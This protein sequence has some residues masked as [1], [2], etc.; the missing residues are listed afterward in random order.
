MGDTW[1]SSLSSVPSVLSYRRS[2][3][4]H[5]RLVAFL[6]RFAGGE[7]AVAEGGV[8]TTEDGATGD[9]APLE[10]GGWSD[11]RS[12]RGAFVANVAPVW[13]RLLRRRRRR[14]TAG[15]MAS[16]GEEMIRQEMVM[17]WLPA[18]CRIEIRA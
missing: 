15:A 2:S 5:R 1:R 13:A 6:V 3:T 7:A 14:P 9:G 17:S 4:S 12:G 8:G 10:D 11:I 16:V 18:W